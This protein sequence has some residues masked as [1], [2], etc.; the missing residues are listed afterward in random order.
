[1]TK[2]LLIFNNIHFYKNPAILNENRSHYGSIVYGAARKSYICMLDPI[3]NHALRLCLGAFRTS[4]VESLQ[5][6]AN[7]PSLASRRNR[8]AVL[9]ALKI[10]S[11]PKNPTFENIFNHRDIYKLAFERKTK[12]IPTFGIRIENLL[13][14]IAIDLSTIAIHHIP[15]IPLWTINLPTINFA[16][17]VN[18][19]SSNFLEFHKQ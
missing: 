14:N 4:P 12:T 7:E 13:N 2:C 1:M 8:L 3:Q 10:R 15:S 6:Q 16:M 18:N 11:N 9:Y 19:K 5:A 17:Q